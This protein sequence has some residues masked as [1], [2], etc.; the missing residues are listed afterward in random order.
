MT[1]DLSRYGLGLV[2]LLGALACDR[3]TTTP[4][5]VLGAFVDGDAGYSAIRYFDSDLVSPNEVCP[6]TRSRL[7]PLIEPIYANGRPIGFC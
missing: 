3:G 4:S 5:D 2:L 1:F 7:N 6:L